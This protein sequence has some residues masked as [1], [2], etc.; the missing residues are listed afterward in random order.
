MVGE[1]N[2]R[3]RYGKVG[4]VKSKSI[5]VNSN[6]NNSNNTDS[7]SDDSDE[8]SY[9]PLDTNNSGGVGAGAGIGTSFL[10]GH[11]IDSNGVPILTNISDKRLACDTKILFKEKRLVAYAASSGSDTDHLFGNLG[12]SFTDTNTIANI[13]TKSHVNASTT[14]SIKNESKKKKKSNV[15]VDKDDTLSAGVHRYPFTFTIPNFSPSTCALIRSYQGDN[16]SNFIVR[17]IVHITLKEQIFTNPGVK[18]LMDRTV[19]VHSVPVIVRSKIPQDPSQSLTTV[20]GG[21]IF[22]GIYSGS[23]NSSSSS[24]SSSSSSSSSN[25]NSSGSRRISGKEVDNEKLSGVLDNK[26]H[27]LY[28]TTGSAVASITAPLHVIAETETDSD[29][30]NGSGNGRGSSSGSGNGSGNRG[31]A[32]RSSS[33][34]LYYN[35]KD[36]HAGVGAASDSSSNSNSNSNSSSAHPESESIP[37]Q[38]LSINTQQMYFFYC[39]PCA[40][41]V[42]LEART[43]KY[44]YCIDEPIVISYKVINKSIKSVKRGI[45][46]ELIRKCKWNANSNNNN[47]HKYES[48]IIITTLH[49]DYGTSASASKTTSA[50]ASAAG[51]SLLRS[52][53]NSNSNTNGNDT[54]E[55]I[56][57]VIAPASDPKSVLLCSTIETT[58]FTVNYYIRIT[59]RIYSGKGKCMA[60]NPNVIIPIHLYSR[61]ASEMNINDNQ[62]QR[63]NQQFQSSELNLNLNLNLKKNIAFSSEDLS[64]FTEMNNNIY[65]I[66]GRFDMI[67]NNMKKRYLTALSLYVQQFTM[68]GGLNYLSCGSDNIVPPLHASITYQDLNM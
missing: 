10:T 5:K 45:Y 25:N 62:R 6:N 13:N 58:N 57:E 30:D 21:S 1:V 66:G 11:I 59:A 23:A 51:S 20:K 28:D 31:D 43:S 35:A 32:G 39:I 29:N 44:T 36:R 65:N 17:I 67:S 47:P 60:T 19:Q 22:S 33:D 26:S 18:V 16:C 53:S 4:H 50:S 68:Y 52:N 24:G 64:N 12:S 15:V 9:K 55:T 61:F 7:D 3:V 8:E 38:P 14:N 63:L 56:V 2:S 42:T 49:R 37:L 41:N 48:E 27:V 34:S 40:G 46:I 54:D